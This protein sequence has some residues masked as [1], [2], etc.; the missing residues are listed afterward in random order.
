MDGIVQILDFGLV[1]IVVNTTN[2]LEIAG[3]LEIHHIIVD[4]KF[5]PN[6]FIA[7]NGEL[8]YDRKRIQ[9]KQLVIHV[10]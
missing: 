2:G 5:C 6:R 10:F 1:C 3:L 9:N 7:K 4:A 8:N